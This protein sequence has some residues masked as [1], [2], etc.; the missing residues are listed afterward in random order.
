MT[1][2]TT[3]GHAVGDST[4]VDETRALLAPHRPRNRTTTCTWWLAILSTGAFFVVAT[5]ALRLHG[6]GWM[7][8]ASRADEERVVADVGAI[9]ASLGGSCDRK[10]QRKYEWQNYYDCTCRRRYRSV[11]RAKT[12]KRVR[13]GSSVDKFYNLSVEACRGKCSS[14]SSCRAAEHRPARGVV[15]KY[16]NVFSACTLYKSYRSIDAPSDYTLMTYVREELR[17]GG[18]ERWTIKGAEELC[19]MRPHHWWSG[20]Q[21]YEACYNTATQCGNHVSRNPDG[22][23]DYQTPTC[24]RTDNQCNGAGGNKPGSGQCSPTNAQQC[25]SKG[26]FWWAG[27][28]CYEA[29]YNTATQCGNHVSRNPDGSCDYKSRVCARGIG[30]RDDCS[31]MGSN[32]PGVTPCWA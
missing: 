27:N 21:C 17:F 1:A 32:K 10:C 19:R 3:A 20:S 31:G 28:K 22:S 18:L 8:T 4:A 26:P 5:F 15:Q 2:S 7:T 24:E 29:C 9:S 12:G 13:Y 16:G 14:N 30:E 11:L 23:C 25:S 6:A